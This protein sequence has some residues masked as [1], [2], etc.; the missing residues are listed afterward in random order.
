[1]M[2]EGWSVRCEGWSVRCEGC[3]VRCEGWR[4]RGLLLL[5]RADHRWQIIIT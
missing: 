5:R 3:S 4:V 2:G 1:M